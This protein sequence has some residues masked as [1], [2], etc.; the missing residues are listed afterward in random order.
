MRLAKVGV[1][2]P[3]A[4]SGKRMGSSVN[5]QFLLLAGKPVLAYTV[6]VFQSSPFVEEIVIV[7]AKEDL[8]LISGL[9][10]THT[11]SKVAKITVGGAIRQASVYTGVK[12]LSAEIGRVVV[13]DGARPLLTLE[14]FHRFLANAQGFPAA[15]T[16]IPLKDTVKRV[17]D[18]GW[19]RET[20]VRDTL[21][22]VQTPQLFDRHVLLDAHEQAMAKG[23]VGTDDASILEWLGYPV[24]V[25]AGAEENIKVTTP[26]D[27]WLAERIIEVRG[28]KSE[29]RQT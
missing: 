27:L 1:V 2:I 18:N 10:K 17:D 12:A 4:G 15:I 21:R 9:V 13:H 25:L 11:Y 6:E 23:F 14:V 20:P 3:A 22:A 28:Q 16:A 8:P 24:K 26:Q 29:V 19:V 7:G 5:K